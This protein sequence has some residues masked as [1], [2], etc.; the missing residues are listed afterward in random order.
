MK[1]NLLLSLIFF[2]SAFMFVCPAADTTFYHKGGDTLTI[3]MGQPG[4]PGAVS[5]THLTSFRN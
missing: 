4:Q 1:R 5:Y 3:D 2:V